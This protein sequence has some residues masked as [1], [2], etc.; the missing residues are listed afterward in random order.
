MGQPRPRSV[1][2]AAIGTGRGRHRY[3]QRTWR[4]E[5]LGT[6]HRREQLNTKRHQLVTLIATHQLPHRQSLDAQ[7]T[8]PRPLPL[9]PSRR[10]PPPTASKPGFTAPPTAA[11]AVSSPRPATL[12]APLRPH[13]RRHR[14]RPLQRPHRR[15]QRQN[16]P[17]QRP[18]L[19]PPLR[20]N[21]DLNDLPLPRWTAAQTTHNNLRSRTRC[22]SRSRAA[23]FR[24]P[25]RRC[26]VRPPAAVRG[27]PGNPWHVRRSYD[28]RG[29]G[30]LGATNPTGPDATHTDSAA[31]F[32]RTVIASPAPGSRTK[33]RLSPG[34][35][36][37][38]TSRPSVNA[39]ISEPSE[40]AR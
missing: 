3:A 6:T 26:R 28:Q 15:H 29:T 14:T 39:T 16:P 30:Y 32:A 7:R 35:T 18:R 11:S 9:Q 22:R 20:P 25:Q 17:H 5:P 10:N 31:V 8:S 38:L 2:S 40:L 1:F 12:P 34:R 23:R 33:T 21:T 37:T 19:R 36:G 4:A 27:T 24:I 13:H